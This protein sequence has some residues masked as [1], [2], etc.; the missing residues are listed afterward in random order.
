MADAAALP[1]L[2]GRGVQQDGLLVDVRRHPGDLL[3]L[4]E[5]PH[6]GGLFV[7][8]PGAAG[9]HAQLVDGAAPED[10]GVH[11]L[12]LVLEGHER[13]GLGVEAHVGRGVGRRALH[14][15]GPDV[16]GA[17]RQLRVLVDDEGQVRP[18]L[19]ELPVEQL[20]LDD[21]VPPRQRERAVGAGPHA[22]PHVG[23]HGVGAHVRV[24]HHRLAAGV[25]QL[26]HAAARLGRL[27]HRG[28]RAPQHEHLRVDLVGVALLVLVVDLVPH[29]HL[30][31]PAL[32]DALER[33]L[34]RRVGDGLVGAAV[35][36]ERHGVARQVALRAARLEHRG[37]AERMAHGDG[38]AHRV[39]PAAA[40]R[41]E[42]RV[43]TVLLDGFG[44][45]GGREV[46]GL[47]P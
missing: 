38:L 40:H 8:L 22:Q 14:V 32:R 18:L 19:G 11:A 45:L 20:V 27:R 4:L 26:G 15:V 10:L 21:V 33:F 43:R 36:E 46:D 30:L 24:H 23:L 13:A 28:L 3:G 2:Q 44:D 37:R 7:D 25:A 42:E 41:G 39:G 35:H 34:G 47:V 1:L 5:R 31:V 29:A 9:G 17:V 6:R 12:V 16:G